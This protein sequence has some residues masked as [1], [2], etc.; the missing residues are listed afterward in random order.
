M[1]A[2]KPGYLVTKT[3]GST[4]LLFDRKRAHG[5]AGHHGWT[6]RELTPA[7]VAAHIASLDAIQPKTSVVSFGQ[8]RDA[9]L[10]LRKST[11]D[12]TLAHVVRNG[13]FR[14]MRVVYHG[15]RTIETPVTDWADASTH[16]ANI[17]AF[18]AQ[19]VGA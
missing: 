17:K 15:S 8:L 7:Q 11:G 4:A 19:A 1:S 9:M 6:V 13:K 5:L 16:L 10:A 3:D 18:G 14:M 2:F 12:K